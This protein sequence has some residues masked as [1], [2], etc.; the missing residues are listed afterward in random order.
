MF[1]FDI[2]GRIDYFQ[3]A[4]SV[5]EN[6]SSDI[7]SSLIDFDISCTALISFFAHTPFILLSSEDIFIGKTNKRFGTWE[8]DNI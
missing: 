6:L 2:D 5:T 4:E 3:I 7:H 8:S 1:F